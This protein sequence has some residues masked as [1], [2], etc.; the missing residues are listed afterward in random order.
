MKGTRDG[1]GEDELVPTLM[2]VAVV[3]ILR[4]VREYHFARA[5]DTDEDIP[6]LWFVLE[7]RGTGDGKQRGPY[8]DENGEPL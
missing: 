7:R 3:R 5:E 1:L 2:H 6:G 8:E 4:I